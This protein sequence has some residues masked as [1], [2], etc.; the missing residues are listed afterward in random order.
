[1]Q[2]FEFVMILVS[3]VIGLG[4]AEL[5]GM[6]ARILRRE[7][8]GGSLHTLWV[9]A[10]LLTLVQLFWAAWELQFRSDWS[11]LE[12]AIFLMPPFLLFLVASL[13]CP[14]NPG[15]TPLDAY[16][17]ERRRP[18]FIVLVAYL[19]SASVEAGVFIGRPGAS[20]VVRALSMI[21]FIALAMSSTRRLHLWGVLIWI[22]TLVAFAASFTFSLA[23][24]GP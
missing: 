1:M 16:F 13:L 4:V 6:L 22:G 7:A 18:F 15:H 24:M 9:I 14:R 10:I 21:M 12:L 11:L 17:L 8:R 5:L 3:I 2:S 20:D 19:V 23:G